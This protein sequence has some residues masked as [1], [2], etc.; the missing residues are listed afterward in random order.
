MT[1]LLN[2]Q[3]QEIKN[4][5]ITDLIGYKNELLKMIFI[6][7]TPLNNN[8]TILLEYLQKEC[9]DIDNLLKQNG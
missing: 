3:F 2:I 4:L 5:S 6:I 9:N 1:A 8:E 7:D